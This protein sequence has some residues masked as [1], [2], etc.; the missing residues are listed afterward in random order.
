MKDFPI[1]TTHLP[2]LEEVNKAA[3][4]LRLKE[5]AEAEER[6]KKEQEEYR[7]K[8]IEGRFAL[9][10]D[11]YKT[12]VEWINKI[13][14]KEVAKVDE[15][16]RIM[17]G[18][19]HADA[20]LKSE[21]GSGYHSWNRKP[22]GKYYFS[23]GYYPDT[24]RFPQK[25]DGTFNYENIAYHIRM[26]HGAWETQRKQLLNEQGNVE[27]KREILKKH[28]LPEYS[29]AFQ[30]TG[31]K[32]EQGKLAVSLAVILTAERCEELI[33]LLKQHKFI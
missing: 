25:K 23:I 15:A 30:V 12:I 1:I 2:S 18:N 28:G 17:I 24:K 20:D 32:H 9:Y 31:S 29:G 13:E 4:E 6:R 27:L 3:E 33:V 7:R 16:C 21:Y 11:H 5:E 19:W 8:L 22:N 14:G 10:G 26:L